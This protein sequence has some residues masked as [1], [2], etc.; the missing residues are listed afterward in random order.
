MEISLTPENQ[1]FVEAQ[2]AAGVFDN[3]DDAINVLVGAHSEPDLSA[4]DKASIQAA[5]NQSR[6][7]YERGEF[8]DGYIA[9]KRV[10]ER[11][12]TKIGG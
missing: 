5:V 10:K 1:A 7:Q 2:I 4:E 3:A 11:L 12:E 8:T 6:A 9:M